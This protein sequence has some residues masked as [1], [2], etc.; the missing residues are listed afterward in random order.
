M[1]RLSSVANLHLAFFIFQ[2]SSPPVAA[3]R[4]LA[5]APVGS[6]QS[7]SPLASTVDI[8]YSVFAFVAL[9]SPFV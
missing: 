4:L 3:W 7:N 5:R 2:S 1:L 9:V 8:C 6:P